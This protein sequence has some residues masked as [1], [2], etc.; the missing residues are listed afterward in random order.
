MTESSQKLLNAMDGI[1][2]LTD[3]EGTILSVGQPQ[4]KGF[5]EETGFLPSV[6]EAAIGTN[7]FSQITGDDVRASYRRLHE[8]VCQGEKPRVTFQY[9]CDGPEVMRQMRL[10]LSRVDQDQGHAAV[11]YQSQVLSEVVRPPIGLLDP[12]LILGVLADEQAYPIVTLC[13]YCQKVAWPVGE[14]REDAR[15]WI[16]PEDYYVR[17]GH[18]EVRISHGIC[19]LCVDMLEMA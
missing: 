9:R 1:A 18:S 5:L 4:W 8:S 17:G 3:S 7:L 11:L 12:D 14:T 16:S 13:S 15:E 2:Y 19:P 6:T 10:S